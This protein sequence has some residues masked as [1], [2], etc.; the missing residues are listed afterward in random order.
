MG[1]LSST[2]NTPSLERDALNKCEKKLSACST[3]PARKN[4]NIPDPLH[5][6]RQKENSVHR[7]GGKMLIP[8]RPEYADY[9]ARRAE[10]RAEDDAARAEDDAAASRLSNRWNHIY[11]GG[12]K[13]TTPKKRY[14]K[15][16]KG[17]RLVRTG[18]RGGKYYIYKGK[19]VYL[20]NN[21]K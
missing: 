5:L 2:K 20:K 1:N 21:C 13:Y 18:S 11:R 7:P 16:P 12:K 14:I 8:G 4:D 17:K 10:R 19:K 9:V 3:G 15:S 6:S